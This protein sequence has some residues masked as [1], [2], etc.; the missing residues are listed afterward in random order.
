MKKGEIVK[1]EITGYAFEG[2]G[3]AKIERDESDKKYV[4]FVHGA[5]PGDIV[6]AR[7]TKKKKN[8]AEA[9]TVN[10]LAPSPERIKPQCKYFG[11][12]G[13][14]KTQDLRYE[15]QTEYKEA[16]V[17]EI[18]EHLG[19][20]T[21]YEF[22]PIL[23]AVKIYR[24]RN[25]MEF[26]F[27]EKRWLTKEEIESGETIEN[28]DFALG[29]H[30][31]RVFDKVLD[32]DECHLHTE[33]SDEILNFTR[34]FFKR[35]NV[36]IYSTKTHEG[37]LRHLVIKTAHHTRETLVNLVT[38][39]DDEN[40]MREYSDALV[41]AI[42]SVTTV[43]N[44]VN[45]R[46][47]QVA[48]GDYEKTYFGKGYIF[49]F[50]GK[51][52][53]RISANSFFQ[54]NTLQAEKL[55]DTAAEFADFSGD[56]IV[57]DLYSG[58]GTIAIYVSEKVREIYAVENV[59]AAVEDAKINMELNNVKNMSFIRADLNKSFYPIARES[60]FP[61]PDVIIADPPR[62]GM[63]PR[64]VNDILKFAPKKIVYVSCNPA[65][66]ARDIS[67]LSEG[68]YRLVKMRPVDMFPHTY[69]IE[70]VA[71]LAREK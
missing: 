15:I 33:T 49:D 18:F 32:I 7:I 4:V 26:S 57:Y 56:E 21:D 43:V 8:Y 47:A 29:L 40:L 13:G 16:Q 38:G 51:F 20:F 37:Y 62:G 52:K 28:R 2:K 9:K 65:T 60:G 19:K 69:H 6:E 30:I 39:Y 1:L 54:T 68:G 66:Q 48:T 44:N 31:P 34:E 53:Y 64:T 55:Y 17:R 41:R 12:C 58:A 25:K 59:E 70:N 24:Y 35:R 63:N 45:L 42:P 5:Y 14:C 61:A 11:T 10:V 50:I 36:S 46:K 71:L 67:L 27:S 23:P 3:V 22:L